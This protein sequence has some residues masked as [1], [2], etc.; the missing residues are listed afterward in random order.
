VELGRQ[1]GGVSQGPSV[2]WPT[3][4]QRAHD[5]E[6]RMHPHTDGP[7]DP[8]RVCET[9]RLLPQRVHQPEASADGPL[10][11]VVMGLRI[12]KV[13]DDLLTTILG[14]LAL[15]LPD[16]VG[17]GLLIGTDDGI[18]VVWGEGFGEWGLG[19]E[20]THQDGELSPFGVEHSRE[21]PEGDL[22][23]SRLVR[24][25]RVDRER[26]QTILLSRIEHRWRSWRFERRRSA[27][28]FR[29]RRKP[30]LHRH[31]EAIPSPIDGLDELWAAPAVPNGLAY[32]FHRTVEHRVADELLRPDL[33]TQLLLGDD[34]VGMRQQVGQNLERFT[35]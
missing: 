25:S 9:G 21:R 28:V 29:G 11:I 33:R 24:E 18:E 7:G 16:N 35:P 30:F 4:A 3:V 22:L 31:Q 1:R 27:L 6:A 8:R 20:D 23:S 14:D 5:D 32:S 13:D 26:R 17:T 34:P 2:V 15:K 10:G 12:A 19:H